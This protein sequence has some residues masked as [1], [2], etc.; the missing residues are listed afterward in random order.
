MRKEEISQRVRGRWEQVLLGLGVPKHH[1]SPRHTSCPVCGGKD[2]YRWSNHQGD[3]GFHCSGPCGP[4]S[5]FDVLMRATG[6]D[7][8][9]A[10]R[11]IAEYLAQHP[12]LLPAPASKSA[13][14]PERNLSLFRS[15]SPLNGQCPAS[16]WL[17]NRGLDLRSYPSSLRYHPRVPYRHDDGSKTEHPAMLALFS[18][19]GTDERTVHL[20]YL[21]AYGQKAKVPHVRRMMPG[22]I[23]P[24]G[25]VRL[26]VAGEVLG[27]AEGIETALAAS[28]LHNVPVW[29]TLSTTH[30]GK[31]KP[32]LSVK[33]VIIF[34]DA[35]NN[36]AGHYAG[37]GLA[38]RL[39]QVD[40]VTCDVRLPPLG[41]DWNDVLRDVGDFQQAAQ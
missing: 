5:A 38:Y 31:F 16:L 21:D 2:R 12:K 20:T 29:A 25:A 18:G 39:T 4:G 22:S 23:P 35:D 36:Y 30:L 3:G 37:Y 26:A 41:M 15:A 24:G 32:P 11:R 40:G 10:R 19:P 8:N 28:I 7:F 33:R 13:Y 1:L 14:D 6:C 17:A 34:A 27:V 9:E